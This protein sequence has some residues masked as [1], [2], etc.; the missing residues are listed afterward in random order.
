VSAP[1]LRRRGL[2]TGPE[3][4]DNDPTAIDAPASRRHPRRRR[5]AC[6]VD[7]M[8]DP[9]PRPDLPFE[10]APGRGLYCNRTLN[11]RALRA[12]GYDMDYTLVHYQV[13]AWE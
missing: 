2:A 8:T 1:S 3:P 9:A 6:P 13:E 4:T 10:P 7:T 11:L 12:I 5:V